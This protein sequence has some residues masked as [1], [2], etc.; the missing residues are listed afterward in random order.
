MP[1]RSSSASAAPRSRQ[2]PASGSAGITPSSRWSPEM[3]ATS[4][5]ARTGAA[6]SSKRT[7]AASSKTTRANARTRRFIDSARVLLRAGN[8]GKGSSSFRHEPFV[9]RGGP[10]GGDGGRGGSIVLRAT[11][12]LT[13]LSDYAR[14]ARYQAEHGGDGA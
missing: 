8:G 6:S 2:A 11:H 4:A 13:D 12:A 14:K 1:A 7:A 5:W 9:P 10:D 3:S